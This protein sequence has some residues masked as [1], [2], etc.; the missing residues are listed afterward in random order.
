MDNE[1]SIPS[2]F[3]LFALSA[4]KLRPKFG[5]QFQE[6]PMMSHLADNVKGGCPAQKPPGETQRALPMWPQDV[7]PCPWEAAKR[8]SP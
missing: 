3:S 5:A 7:R 6:L 1:S 4:R 2:R 8:L